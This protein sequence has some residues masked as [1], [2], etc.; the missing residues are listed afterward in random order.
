MNSSTIDND[1]TLVS[2][3]PI[4]KSKRSSFKTPFAKRVTKPCNENNK[5]S[6]SSNQDPFISSNKSTK[7]VL[8]TQRLLYNE[9]TTQIKLYKKEI[10]H[11]ND[12]IKILNKY[13][14]ELKTDQL[15]EKWQSIC[16]KAMSYLFNTTLFKIDK[17]GGYE[18]FIKKEIEAEK[19]RIEYQLDDSIGN[20]ISNFLE[21]EEF[22]N[23]PL[24]DQEE[25][26]IQLERKRDEV[27]RVKEKSLKIL[28]QRLE[29]CQGQEMTM[30]E[31]ARRL[32]VEYELVF[33]TL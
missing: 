24:D 5:F 30:K 22:K 18:E 13:D 32:K 15:I 23:L 7:V 6:T 29:L 16:Q 19:A 14:K 27:E 11:I 25:C 26:K 31:L 17:M 3:S 8:K 1:T 20:E 33:P 12:A 10:S 28:D 9:L 4:L 21:S 2:S